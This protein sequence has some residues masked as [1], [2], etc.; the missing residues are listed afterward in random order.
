MLGEE[1]NLEQ[2]FRYPLSSVLL[3]LVFPD[4]TLRQN[5]KY[6]FHNYLFDVACEST[7]SNE[8]RWV[9]DTVSVMRAIKFKEKYKEWLKTVIK[10][11]LPISS[12][13]SLSTVYVNDLY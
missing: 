5:P 6:C 7:R 8:G 13:K 1:V 3:S 4:S 12:L 10:F 2:A 9:I 11:T